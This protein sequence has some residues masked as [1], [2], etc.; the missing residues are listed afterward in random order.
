MKKW[1]IIGCLCFV[2][3]V[4]LAYFVKVEAALIVELGLAAFG[5]TAIIVNV[6]KTNKDKALPLWQ[7]ILVI[8]L[9]VV[10]GVL[11][12][13]GGLTSTIFAEISGAVL[14]LLAVIFGLV[15]ARKG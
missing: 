9:A 8:V 10:G 3:A 7:T 5:L 12:C 6:I 13:I 14:A 11:V 1:G 4:V 2:A 15:F